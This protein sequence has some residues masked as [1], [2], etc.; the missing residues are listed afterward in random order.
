MFSRLVLS[1]LISWITASKQ[2]N[3]KYSLQLNKKKPPLL[4]SI[5]KIN[6][7]PGNKMCLLLC[8]SI[9]SGILAWQTQQSLSCT[10][11]LCNICHKRDYR[12]FS[13]TTIFL[14]GQDTINY[15]GAILTTIDTKPKKM[16]SEAVLQQDHALCTEKQPSGMWFLTSVEEKQG[17]FY[18]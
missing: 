14:S 16:F 11:D 1:L 17:K 2:H 18:C 3:R 9:S 6:A 5:C 10:C 13:P 15:Q 8:A 4:R 12:T 7:E